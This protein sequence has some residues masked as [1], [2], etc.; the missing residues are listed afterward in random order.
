MNIDEAL[1]AYLK[2]QT[3]LEAIVNSRIFFEILPQGTEYPAVVIQKISDV[4]DHY[5]M[6]QCELE[7]PMYQF[8]SLG[9]TKASARSVSDQLKAALCDFQGTMSGIIIQK[10]EL[11]NEIS[12]L[13]K[14]SDGIL[15]VYYDDL[16]FE[17]NFIRS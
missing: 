13:D 14:T 10:I 12:S 3:G 1:I 15:K 9:I 16:E 2:S 11:V 8:S 17:V 6:G 4:K 5:L 7:R